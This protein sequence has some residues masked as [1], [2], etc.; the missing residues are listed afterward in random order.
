MFVQ[1]YAEKKLE[2]IRVLSHSIGLFPARERYDTKKRNWRTVHVSKGC[3]DNPKH[4][5]AQNEFLY[6]VA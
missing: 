5:V 2:V 1:G 6:L 4:R 3:L